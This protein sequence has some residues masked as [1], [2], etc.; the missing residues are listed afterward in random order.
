VS[1]KIG[2]RLLTFMAGIFIMLLGVATESTG[3]GKTLM[4]YDL[5]QQ[6]KA[7]GVK[8]GPFR[9]RNVLYLTDAGYD[10]NVYRTPNNPIKDFSI[11]AGP[12]F[13]LY[14]PIKQ[15]IIISIYESPQYVYFVK[16]KRERTWNNYFNGQVNIVLN[17]FFI[18]LGK[19]YSVAREIWNTEIDIRPQR[20]EDSSQGSLQWQI[21]KKTSL[22]FRFIQAKYNYEDLSF[23]GFGIKPM[24]NR[25]ENRANFTGY[26][27]V[28]FRTMFFLNF[29]YGY[30]KFQDPSNP[31]DSKN[32]G[33]YSGFEFSPLGVI[34]G[35]MNLGY[36][37]LDVLKAGIKDYQGIVGDTGISIRVFMPLR[38]SANYRRD[39]QF[40]AWYPY[41]YYLENIIGGGASLYVSRNIRLDYNHQWGKNNYPPITVGQPSSLTREDNYRAQ[42]VGIYLRMKKTIGLGV[43]AT[44]WER[45]SSVLWLNGKQTLIGANLIYDF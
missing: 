7:A 45:N 2:N 8:L 33:I 29:E 9:I 26:Y 34:R 25:T 44:Q 36:K 5:E 19:G 4:G 30:F 40:S 18:A 39:V 12:G 3:W 14:L 27:R 10:S 6:I 37:Y 16:T 21:T 31:R 42:S 35:R 41:A 22:L 23:G 13:Y 24:L 38:I 20:T 43:L 1:D 32:Y 15:K 28:S 11:S 17:R